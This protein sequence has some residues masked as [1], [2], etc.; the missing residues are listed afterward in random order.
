MKTL[1]R[2]FFAARLFLRDE[3]HMTIRLPIRDARM[4][5]KTM[6]TMR[7]ES[8]RLFCS[9]MQTMLLSLAVSQ[10]R[11]AAQLI[12]GVV[13]GVQLELV[14]PFTVE[15]E[16]MEMEDNEVARQT[17]GPL[18]S[19]GAAVV[20]MVLVESELVVEAVEVEDESEDADEDEVEDV[21]AIEVELVFAGVV[22]AEVV[23]AADVVVLAVLVEALV[24]LVV[25]RFFSSLR[26]V[27]CAVTGS[28]PQS[29]AIHSAPVTDSDSEHPSPLRHLRRSSTWVNSGASDTSNKQRRSPTSVPQATVSN[30]WSRDKVSHWAVADTHNKAEAAAAMPR[31]EDRI[32]DGSLRKTG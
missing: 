32:F 22:E 13:V 31:N 27:F 7:P 28:F 15:V 16:Q 25:A 23:I 1:S 12:M 17:K 5:P 14:A 24:E 21:E 19:V 20:A 30:T 26:I 11:P 29:L 9:F 18:V 10:M 6:V 3:K 4:T 8:V 2:A